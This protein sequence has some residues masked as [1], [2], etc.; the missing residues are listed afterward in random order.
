MTSLHGLYGP[1]IQLAVCRP[2]PLPL[3]SAQVL[4]LKS[5]LP[6]F[7]VSPIW[8]VVGCIPP[9]LFMYWLLGNPDANFRS[10]DSNWA[11]GEVSFKAFNFE[12]V[13]YNFE[14]F[15]LNCNAE[16]A[17]ILRTTKMQ[18]WNVFAWP[19]YATNPKWNVPYAAPDKRIG[20]YFPTGSN[21]C[22]NGGLR[23]DDFPIVRQR[24][25]DLVRR[26]ARGA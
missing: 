15:R 9:V 5:S 4:P 1:P 3:W 19:S 20:S 22:A 7:R 24:A 6:R 23:A 11:K 10:S 16:S 26:F 13:A 17:Q 8:K 25:D 21:H 2:Q 14:I 12:G 18:W